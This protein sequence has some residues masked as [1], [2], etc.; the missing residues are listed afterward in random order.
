MTAYTKMV[1]QDGPLSGLRAY[2]ASRPADRQDALLAQPLPP[3]TDRTITGV[4][5]ISIC[6]PR[7]HFT[8][9][10]LERYRVLV[11]DAAE[12][13]RRSWAWLRGS[14]S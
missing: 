5:S 8:P 13:I 1:E 3:L 14:R 12:E 2:S 11:R 4:G 10:A 9:E 7:D 6:G